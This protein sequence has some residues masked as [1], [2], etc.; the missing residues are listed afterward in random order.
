M[1]NER[2]ICCAGEASQK[3]SSWTDRQHSN[4]NHRSIT[5][6]FYHYLVMLSWWLIADTDIDGYVTSMKLLKLIFSI[7]WGAK[8]SAGLVYAVF[9]RYYEV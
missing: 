5:L 2:K 3:C 1:G 9:L 8:L 7:S 4:L 6:V